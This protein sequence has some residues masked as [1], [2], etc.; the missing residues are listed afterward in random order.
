MWG[1]VNVCSAESIFDFFFK[2]IYIHR[3]VI[4]SKEK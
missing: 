1:I 3:N 2:G 4:V